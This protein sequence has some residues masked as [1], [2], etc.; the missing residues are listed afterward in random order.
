MQFLSVARRAVSC[1]M[2]LSAFLLAACGKIGAVTHPYS[3]EAVR[4]TATQRE[5]A[6]HSIFVD[7]GGAGI[8]PRVHKRGLTLGDAEYEAYVDTI[9]HH[10][11]LHADSGY[12]DVLIRIHGGL[13]SL[14]GSPGIASRMDAEIRN[15]SAKH[16][17]PLFI[18]WDSGILESY[19]EHLFYVRQGERRPF[20]LVGAPFFFAADL[21]RAAARL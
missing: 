12:P 2:V 10:I 16:I 4:D 8:A 21:G 6:R 5:L 14:R 17:Y 20:D 1:A 7:N 3:L 19:S 18:N 9:V 15:D 11:R 13:N